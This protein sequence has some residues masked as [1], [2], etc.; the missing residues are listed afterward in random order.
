[1]PTHPLRTHRG[2]DRAPV[3][4]SDARGGAR[5][6]ALGDARCDRQATSASVLTEDGSVVASLRL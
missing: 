5:R 3:N 1:V 2:Q 6:H 4:M